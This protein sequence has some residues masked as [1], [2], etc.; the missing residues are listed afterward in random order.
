MI[1]IRARLFSS[2]CSPSR[3]WVLGPFEIGEVEDGEEE[4]WQPTSITP[5]LA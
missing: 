5:M 2:L 1:F 3:E 4:E